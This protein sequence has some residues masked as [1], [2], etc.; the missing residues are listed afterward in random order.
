MPDTYTTNLNLTKPEVGGSDNTWGTKLNSNFDA[1]DALFG[2]GPVLLVSKGGT[3]ASTA[4]GARSNLGLGT[5]A[6]QDTDNVSVGTLT[7]TGAVG[8][9][10]SSPTSTLDVAGS[11]R[12]SSL[13]LTNTLSV[14]G[15]SSFSGSVSCNTLSVSSQLTVP[16]TASIKDSSNRYVFGFGVRVKRTTTYTFSGAVEVTISWEG[17]DWNDDNMWSSSSASN[18]VLTKAGYYLVTGQ[19]SAYT[20]SGD[21]AYTIKL[22]RGG[23]LVAAKTV[24]ITTSERVYDVSFLVRETVPSTSYTI[25][26][27]ASAAT[28]HYITTNT[29]FAF[30]CL[31]TF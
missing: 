24:A 30:T 29:K 3:G 22:Y 21:S 18:V 26:V 4:A 14:S 2:S 28:T 17:T 16:N 12:A 5:L 31:G 19:F 27:Q 8:V 11:F 6:T 10:T 13:T 9:G 20:H 1:I 23:V 25:A 7:T 15:T